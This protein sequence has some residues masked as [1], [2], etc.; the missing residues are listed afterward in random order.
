LVSVALPWRPS[1]SATFPLVADWVPVPLTPMT[2][3]VV[4]KLLV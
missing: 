1:I 4:E 3:P 2:E